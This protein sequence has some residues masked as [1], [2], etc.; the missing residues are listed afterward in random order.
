MR[1]IQRASIP[2]RATSWLGRQ[3]RAIDADLTIDVTK[4]WASRRRTMSG[5]GILAALE[6]M[7]GFRKRCMYCGD[8]HA[9][10][11]EH[12]WPKAAYRDRAFLWRNLLWICQ[13][14]NRRKNGKFPVAPCG[15][16]LI[17]NPVSADPWD[18]FVYVPETGDVMPRVE[19]VGVARDIAEH[20]ID[21]KYTRVNIEAVSE[22]RRRD[23]RTLRRAAELLLSSGVPVESQFIE[24]ATDLDHPELVQWFLTREGALREPYS[25]IRFLFPSVVDNTMLALNYF[26]HGIM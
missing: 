21:P 9:C 1:A 4:F 20:T 25:E 7:A 16:A 18:Y 26:H 11:I 17:L 12:F 24:A 3:Q 23:A 6:K 15:T 5:N 10:D 19:L 13:P 2:S 14:C 22:G 8:S